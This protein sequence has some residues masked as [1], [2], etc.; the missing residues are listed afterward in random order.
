MQA[1]NTRTYA[2]AALGAMLALASLAPDSVW[3]S[4]GKVDENDPT[5]QVYQLVDSS[6]GGVLKHFCLLADVYTDAS[7]AE[8]RH[9]LR[10]EY[11]KNRAF[12]RLE[13][14]VRSVGKMD[15]AQ[16]AAYTPEQ[17]YDFGE[18]DQ[19]KYMKTD[20]G[21]LGGTGD[22]YLASSGDGPLR[23]QPITEAARKRYADFIAQ[24]V[25]PA[26]KNPPAH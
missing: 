19:E 10:L 9:V 21:P 13:L 20:P 16:L 15:P 7:G 17:I 4:R 5:L 2:S 1:A 23:S 22:L 11:D 26:L 3:A 6:R 12:G 14:Y 18:S 24:Y 25:L 8:Y